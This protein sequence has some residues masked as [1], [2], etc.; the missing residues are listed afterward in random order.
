MSILKNIKESDL[1]NKGVKP[2]S[3]G[4]YD[5]VNSSLYQSN[6]G[7]KGT[8]PDIEDYTVS[9]QTVRL[10]E[11]NLSL[12]GEIPKDNYKTTGPEEANF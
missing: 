12:K 10:K 11:S 3:F 2:D 8:L 4:Q 7:L 6:L 5:H 9:E 1:G